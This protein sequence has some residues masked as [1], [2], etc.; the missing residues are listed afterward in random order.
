M[1]IRKK[2]NEVERELVLLTTPQSLVSEQFRRLRTN[3]NFSSA[4]EK[5]HSL[6][7]TSANAGEGK[8]MMAA[9]LAV[10]YAQEGKTILL[11][12][13]DM[14]NPTAH[15]TFHMKNDIGIS[16]LLAEET[17]PEVAIRK[18]AIKN[19]D[20]L[21]SGPVPLNP[22]ELLSSKVL[23]RLI[24]KLEKSYD[25]VIFDSPPI[26]SVVD[27]QIIAHKCD[28]S[29][30]VINSGKTDREQALRAKQALVSSG[31]KLVGVILNNFQQR[32]EKNYIRQSL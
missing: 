12:D 2:K 25:L 26:L 18:T 3:L 20:L 10:A 6:I 9:N 21:C 31:S 28:G 27:G 14:R 32:P 16:N 15:K 1:M 22:S 8:S 7:I 17:I 13:S 30:L 5:I 23:E 19:L 4:E 29:L 24:D 11:V